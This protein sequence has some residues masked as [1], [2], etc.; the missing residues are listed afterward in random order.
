MRTVKNVPNIWDAFNA[1]MASIP[2]NVS[3]RR[4]DGDHDALAKTVRYIARELGQKKLIPLSKTF[5][6]SATAMAF[7]AGDGIVVKVI[8]RDYLGQPDVFMHLPALT[9]ETIKTDDN[10]FV[11]KTYPYIPPGKVNR[12]DIEHMRKTLQKY[13]LNFDKGDDQAKNVH[14]LPNKDRTMIGIDSSMFTDDSRLNRQNV[15]DKLVNDW[16]DFIHTL[17][18][19]YAEVEKTGQIPKQ[20]DGTNFKMVSIHDKKSES[21]TFEA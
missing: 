9:Q 19:I 12:N 5:I 14:R 15:P 11:I 13:G 4:L 10:E 7:Y 17:Y 6:Q 18:P 21:L 3:C 8:P 1:T 16:H 2:Q 20:H